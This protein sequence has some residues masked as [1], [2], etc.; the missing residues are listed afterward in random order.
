MGGRRHLLDVG[1]DGQP[2]LAAQRQAQEFALHRRQRH[3][4]RCDIAGRHGICSNRSRGGHG[5]SRGGRSRRGQGC[6]RGGRSRRCC[7]GGFC[8]RS[9]GGWSRSRF[10]GRR[11][12]RWGACRWQGYL[13]RSHDDSR[14][15][16]GRDDGRR[17]WP[18]RRLG[19]TL[20]RQVGSDADHQALAVF[21]GS[22]GEFGRA[23]KIQLNLGA[24]AW[25]HD[26]DGNVADQVGRRS[27]VCLAGLPLALGHAAKNI[28]KY[29]GIGRFPLRKMPDILHGNGKFDFQVY[30][31]VCSRLQDDVVDDFVGSRMAGES[32]AEQ[33]PEK[34]QYEFIAGHYG[35]AQFLE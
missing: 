22:D 3:D 7:G 10:R 17:R 23:G 33:H 4:G 29:R 27:P 8:R 26:A 32:K 18:G 30:F 11:G 25:I 31:A 1:K 13:G 21:A 20:R 35:E 14:C 28:E 6:A 19:L 5:R 16:N 15:D 2:V 12:G 24:G 34:K 9:S